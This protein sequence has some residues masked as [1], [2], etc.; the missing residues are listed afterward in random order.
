MTKP[1]YRGNWK[2][3]AAKKVRA[4][5]ALFGDWCPGW[6]RSA[7]YSADLCLDHDKRLDPKGEFGK[8]LCR[9]CNSRKSVLSDT[10][11]AQRWRKKPPSPPEGPRRQSR[12]W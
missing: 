2:A 8:V 12:K 7:H 11:R 3:I 4:H 10:P 6:G 5:K 9:S 1:A